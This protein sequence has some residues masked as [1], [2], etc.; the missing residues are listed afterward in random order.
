MGLD[1]A[2][3]DFSTLS[4]RSKNLVLPPARHRSESQQA[5]TGH[6]QRSRIEPQMGRWK[7]V[8]G[9]KLRARDFN[10]QKTE[11]RTRGPRLGSPFV[12]STE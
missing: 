4:R 7:T 5:S 11:A 10:S 8:I 1:V 12:L 2:P 9:A 3:P 6:N